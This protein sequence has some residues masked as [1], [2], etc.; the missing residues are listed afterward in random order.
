MERH[1]Y[2]THHSITISETYFSNESFFNK[3]ILIVFSK[4]DKNNET[5]M[6]SEITELNG[7]KGKIPRPPQPVSLLSGTCTYSSITIDFIA[8]SKVIYKEKLNVR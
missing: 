7:V 4:K 3:T 6:K 2:F 1:T 8:D 5:F